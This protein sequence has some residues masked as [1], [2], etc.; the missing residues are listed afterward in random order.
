M[1][2]LWYVRDSEKAWS[3][4]AT[5]CLFCGSWT[6]L[7]LRGDV[8]HD[9]SDRPTSIRLLNL[10]IY[11]YIHIHELLDHVLLAMHFALLEKRNLSPSAWQL[12][13]KDCSAQVTKDWQGLLLNHRTDVGNESRIS[14]LDLK[15]TL[16][17][18]F[19]FKWIF[20]S[21]INTTLKNVQ[22][23]QWPFEDEEYR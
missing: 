23:H 1:Q 20:G 16:P 8:R 12:T 9:E 19:A 6:R 14:S 22:V 4:S 17:F 2:R 15:M 3:H 21:F 13:E 18:T 7:S 5:R 10:S 11:V